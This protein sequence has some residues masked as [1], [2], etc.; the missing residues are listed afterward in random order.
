MPTQ[1]NDPIT[2]G[3]IPAYTDTVEVTVPLR[4]DDDASGSITVH[5]HVHTQPC[6]E[7][8]CLAPRTD[9]VQ[10]VIDIA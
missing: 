5:L 2:G 10:L 3:S 6:D 1:I 8:A 9:T 7:T 4:I